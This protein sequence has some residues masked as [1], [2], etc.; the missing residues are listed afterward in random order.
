MQQLQVM[1]FLNEVASKFPNAISLASGRP[2]PE[3]FN[4]EEWPECQAVFK[5]QYANNRGISLEKAEQLL[6]QY[7]PSAGIIND[8]ISKHIL[9]DFH[10]K[11]KPEQIIITNGCQEALA[12]FCLNE[13][14][15]SQDCVLA[16]D[17]SYIGFSGLISAISKK[18]E[19]IDIRKIIDKTNPEM[20]DW[21]YLVKRVEEI[22]AT[23]QNPKA[24]YINPDFNNPLAYRL[25]E[26]ARIEFLATCSELEI[27][28]IEDD[29]YSRFNYTNRHILSLKAL[30]THGIVY[31]I[32]S[33][34]KTF[35]PGI[36]LGYLVLP[37]DDNKG[38]E[39]MVALKSFLTLN[40][41]S[42]V[43]SIAA[44]YLLKNDFSLQ[45]RVD[46]LTPKYRQQRDA[47]LDALRTHFSGVENVTWNVP[48]GGF[49]CVITLPFDFSSDNVFVCAAEEGVVVMPVGFF[50]LNPDAWKS[51]VRL[52]FSN[53]EPEVLAEGINRFSKYIKKLLAKLED[54]YT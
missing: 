2:H 53:C 30:D 52:A 34:S 16:I 14:K 54:S 35:C 29:P 12:I 8:V 37:T 24:I 10:I 42:V 40:T 48:E 3:F 31:H 9:T 19:P 28:V 39:D 51:K 45:K 11:A 20:F 25:N 5:E 23:G 21:K 38:Y 17:P 1:N 7:G 43:Q 41:A 6:C 36:R 15:N 32:G 33:F 44:G 27:K 26:Q 49:F 4:T 18:I 50:S 46:L 22:K 47:L 13:L